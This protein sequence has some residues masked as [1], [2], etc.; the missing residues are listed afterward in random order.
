MRKTKLRTPRFVF[1]DR[2]NIENYLEEQAR[3]GWML[4]SISALGWKFRRIQ[5]C[6]IYFAVTY[7]PKA[8]DYDPEPSEKQKLFMEM[9]EHTGWKLVTTSAQMQIFC[10]D[11][12]NPIPIETDAELE[13]ENIHR[14]MKRNFLPSHLVIVFLCILQIRRIVSG[15]LDD[16]VSF[17]LNYVSQFSGMFWMLMALFSLGE[18]LCY[19]IWRS[20]AKKAVKL[21]S[22]A[23]PMSGHRPFHS[24]LFYGAIVLIPLVLVFFSNRRLAL[25]YGAIYLASLIVVTLVMLMQR[26]VTA[27]LKK[28]KA[29]TELNKVGTFAATYVMLFVATFLIIKFGAE[30]DI[31]NSPINDYRGD[32]FRVDGDAPVLS[33]DDLLKGDFEGYTYDL[34]VEET[35][36]IARLSGSHAYDGK[37][38]DR[39]DI[40]YS[41]TKFKMPRLYDWCFKAEMD[42]NTKI[43][44][45]GRVTFN[46]NQ[47]LIPI[48]SEPWGV[49]NVYRLYTNERPMN[50]YVV[51]LEDRLIQVTADWELTT[52]QKQTIVSILGSI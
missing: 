40:R 44:I 18:I 41:V 21:G 47:K 23:V 32:T 25:I 8:S 10:N 39:P 11:S 24:S 31:L 13:L 46:F 3:Q 1:Y 9:C 33:A 49:E 28:K 15:V 36:F 42:R 7:F 5:P 27:F 19:F 14:A 20:K 34:T 26:R 51:R 38:A 43:R 45:Q 29:E 22:G 37:D 6:N 4:E 12:E 17:L 16:P 35:V 52:E 50:T 48:Y 2:I 30:A